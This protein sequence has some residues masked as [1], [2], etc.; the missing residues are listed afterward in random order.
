MTEALTERGRFGKNLLYLFL[1]S[2]PITYLGAILAVFF[3]EIIGHGL[4]AQLLGGRFKGFGVALDAMGW[5][6]IDAK[7]LSEQ[8]MAVMYLGGAASTTLFSLL[9]FAIGLA[10]RRKT[11]VRFL[12]LILGF[13]FMLDGLPYYFW[14]AIFLGGIG[15]F[16]M[17]NTLYPDAP[18]RL[19]VI[20]LCGSLMTA[21]IFL[22]NA[23]YYRI[24]LRLVG[25][26]RL[27]S[28]KGKVA[29]SLMIFLQQTICWFIFDWDQ[30]VPGVGML[31][32]VV[33]AALAAGALHFMILSHASAGREEPIKSTW[34]YKAPLVAAWA[35][36]AATMLCIA[37][38]L[39]NGVNLPA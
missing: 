26:G 3:H 4:T 19:A 14:D 30:I 8:R 37:L 36:C 11:Q 13:S 34:R 1:F 2:M 6:D 25:E 5:A 18:M 15:D 32:S 9:F 38:W 21:M 20:A 33:G 10:F 29:I 7:G 31:P 12:F 23:L 16:S 35:A 27:V 28:M 24:A 17:I 22:F 39:Q